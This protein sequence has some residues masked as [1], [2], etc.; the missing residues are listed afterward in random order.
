MTIDSVL[1]AELVTADGRHLL[2]DTSTEP[3]LFWAI[4][5]GGGNFGVV[6]RF[7]FRLNAMPQFTGGILVLPAT[8]ETIAG[9]SAASL[10]APDELSTIGNVMP[11]PPLPF[12]PA[13][14]HGQ[15]VIFAMM[16]FAGDDA[17][18]QRA[19]APFRGL[20]ATLADMVQPSPYSA[21]YPPED[22]N[23]KPTAVARTMFSDGIS[24]ETARTIYDYLSKSDAAMR[25]AQIRALGG[26]MA[27]VPS[28]ATAFAHRT[29][30]MLIN[31]AAFYQGD[32][33]REKRREWV[34][35]FKRALQPHDDSAY[36]GF[37]TDDGA[38]RLRA[39]YPGTT[40]DRLRK[41]KAAV[42]PTNL[43]RL[44]QNVSPSDA[45]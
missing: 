44:N 42:D 13:E 33:D 41:V 28:D 32:A 29:K 37:L 10:E 20:A 45:I 17:A 1:A 36:V 24:I 15:L 40:G 12:L 9:F 11:A 34:I 2:V 5:G 3:E 19:L 8:P 30:P 21:M 16:A 7:K 14:H 23:Y 25:V 6:T 18:A 26:A 43:F 39:T 22:P 38:A 31:V 27:R 35:D 4:R